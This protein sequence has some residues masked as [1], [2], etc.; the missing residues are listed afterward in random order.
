[1]RLHNLNKNL[2][3]EGVYESNTESQSEDLNNDS[4]LGADVK[5]RWSFR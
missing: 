4:S 1:M 5:I 3:V 2:S